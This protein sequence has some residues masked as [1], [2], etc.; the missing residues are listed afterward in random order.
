MIPSER[1]CGIRKS[2]MIFSKCK[3]RKRCRETK[4]NLE[5]EQNDV[6]VLVFFSGPSSQA[7]TATRQGKNIDK[8]KNIIIVLL[9]R[10]CVAW[11]DG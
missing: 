6:G 2:L 5:R 11:Q 7:R 8:G 1:K 9:K 4:R 3:T 10:E